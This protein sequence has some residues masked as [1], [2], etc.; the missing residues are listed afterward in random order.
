MMFI[1]RTIWNTEMDSLDKILS[2]SWWHWDLEGWM[3]TKLWTAV[4]INYNMHY[5]VSIQQNSNEQRSLVPYKTRFSINLSW[6]GEERMKGFSYNI[7]N[8]SG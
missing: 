6:N 1:V 4:N 3:V 7:M 2:F 5:V 8:I